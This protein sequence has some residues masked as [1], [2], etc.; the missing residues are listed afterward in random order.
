MNRNA[1]WI[2]LALSTAAALALVTA[3]NGCDGGNSSTTGTTT[4]STTTSTTSGDSCPDGAW[5]FCGEGGS[6]GAGG[7]SGT[8]GAGGTGAQDTLFACGTRPNLCRRVQV[9]ERSGSWSECAYE[10]ARSDDACDPF[11]CDGI[12][13]P[14]RTSCLDDEVLVRYYIDEND[15]PPTALVNAAPS[16]TA[17]DLAISGDPT[18]T[19]FEAIGQRG[20]RWTS[21]Q[22]SANAYINAF[23]GP[24]ISSPLAQLTIELVLDI[25][26]IKQDTGSFAISI[27]GFDVLSATDM[28]VVLGGAD[29]TSIDP[30]RVS[31]LWNDPATP[32]A[33]WAVG[34][35]VRRVLHLVVDAK[36]GM[37][38]MSYGVS[39][40]VDGVRIGSMSTVVDPLVIDGNPTFGGDETLVLGNAW[41]GS[42]TSI[43][44]IY[45]AALYA[46]VLPE[47][48]V[49]KHAEILRC[50]DD[51]PTAP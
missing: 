12:N 26:E 27:G 31:L 25:D 45:Y 4:T 23:A 22:S 48:T 40:Y 50:D 1:P 46:S 35:G 36:D 29:S 10:I 42:R 32:V 49:R 6:G 41:N 44:K 33:T 47:E 3:S 7:S 28:A 16:G 8:A 13:V 20:L 34:T 2:A 11:D 15:E 21:K 24:E 51:T 5:R 19:Y 39:L 30:Q 14:A 17:Y 38:D 43:G 37:E 9:C 18:M